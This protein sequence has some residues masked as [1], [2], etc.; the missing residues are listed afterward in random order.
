[1]AVPDGCSFAALDEVMQPLLDEPLEPPPELA[2]AANGLAYR[3]LHWQAAVQRQQKVPVFG[4]HRIVA[5]QGSGHQSRF[6]VAIPY[7]APQATAAALDWTVRSINEL[8]D[9]AGAMA[10]VAGLHEGFDQLLKGLR[11]YSLGG[12]NNFHLLRAAHDLDV[13]VRAVTG[14]TYCYGYG[15]N[16]RWLNS[17]VT[18]LTPAMGVQIAASKSRT[19]QVLRLSGV[20]VPLHRAV[21]SEQHALQ[22]AQEL[23]Y[24]VVIKPDDQEQGRGVAAGLRD[25][26]ALVAAYQVAMRHSRKIL[27]E[28]HHPG[29]D[30]R[31][32]VLK[33]RVIKILHRRAGGVMGDG[34]H[35]IAELVAIEQESPRFKKA[36]RQTG[37]QLL[38]LDAE[39]LGLLAEHH[40]RADIVAAARDFVVLRRKNNISAGGIQTLIPLE[41][42]HPDNLGLAVRSSRAVQLDLCGVDLLLPDISR[43]WLETGAVIIEMNSKPQIGYT[44]SPE[45]YPQL[46]RE[47]LN[48]DGRVPVH[49]L[50]CATDS[51]CPGDQQL[52]SL[53]Q[54]SRCNGL[55]TPRGAWVDGRK[56]SEAAHA[57]QA[58]RILLLDKS[59]T[60][61]L[62]V[63]TAQEILAHGLPADRF[64]RIM[65]AGRQGASDQVALALDRSL[66]MLKSVP[67]RTIAAAAAG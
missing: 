27:V 55:A 3:L 42:A 34:V 16:A 17:T 8:L 66:A 44:T 63:V 43:S 53:M 40:L 9:P 11:K 61:A 35:T 13:P 30:Y 54:A 14:D 50:V 10:D 56:V 38:E 59:V 32:T 31:L 39:A 58:A 57:F 37:K 62:C 6:L 1:M 45:L 18:D 19:A 15:A 7:H 24:P 52:Q 67:A 5:A 51:D 21:H 12:L 25:D 49:L 26:T 22:V 65:V 23:G 2:G 4:S 48:G 29:E 47:L 64:D 60:G 33:D 28:K 46:L 20:P 36:F 41:Q